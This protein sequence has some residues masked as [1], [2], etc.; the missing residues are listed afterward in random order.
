MKEEDERKRRPDVKV[1]KRGRKT[2]W[3]KG[4]R[5]EKRNER[6]VEFSYECREEKSSQ[7]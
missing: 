1:S 7:R 2:K 4:R 5:R 3:K 6:R